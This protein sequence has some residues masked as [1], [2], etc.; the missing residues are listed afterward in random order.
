MVDSNTPVRR[1][2]NYRGYEMIVE[3]AERLAAGSYVTVGDWSLG[4]ILDHLAKAFVASIDGVG[5][6]MSW[7]VRIFG[8][9]FLKGRFLNKTL[10]A[11]FKFPD[12]PNSAVAPDE[13][14]S[15]DAGLDALRRAVERCKNEKQRSLHPLF[16]RLDRP[17]W[18]R[19]NLR[20]AELHMSF[21]VP[22]DD[23]VLET[24]SVP[25]Q[26]EASHVS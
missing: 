14:T 21:I 19:F 22:T 7:P 10:P 13:Q 1:T 23:A 20:H 24:E 11:G 5:G 8:R 3:D 4:Q 26:S 25:S 6:L 18:D 15:V 17:A 12:G 9:L 2:V 16:G